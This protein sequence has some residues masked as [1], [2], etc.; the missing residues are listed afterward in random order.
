MTHLSSLV[1]DVE[2][3]RF[4]IRS[5]FEEADSLPQQPLSLEASQYYIKMYLISQ[6]DDQT[7]ATWTWSKIKEYPGIDQIVFDFNQHRQEAY[8]RYLDPK[9]IDL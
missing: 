6:D 7:R 9:L 3:L 4:D 1:A 8:V 2:H 5:S